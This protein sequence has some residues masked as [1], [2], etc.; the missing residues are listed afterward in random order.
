VRRSV[1]DDGRGGDVVV[2]LDQVSHLSACAVAALLGAQARMAQA[3]NVLMLVCAP[4]SPASVI[5]EVL[6]VRTATSV[7]GPRSAGLPAP[8]PARW[9]P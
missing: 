2:D 8:A 7:T 3:R 9:P 4:G 1:V 6:G 5:L